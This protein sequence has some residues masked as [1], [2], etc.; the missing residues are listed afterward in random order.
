M[1]LIIIVMLMVLILIALY[2]V[3]KKGNENAKVLDLVV[4]N[5]LEGFRREIEGSI[6][7]SKNEMT[8]ARVDLNRQAT[9]TLKFLVEMQSTIEKVISQQEEANKLGQSLKDVLA[10]PK[11]RGNYGEIILEDLLEK[12]LPCGMWERQYKISDGCVVDV[13]VKYKDLLVPIDA[14]FP[15]DNY[16]KYLECD[17]KQDKDQYWKLF[18]R[19]LLNQI[20]ETAKYVQ[21][22]HGT[23]DFALMFIPSEA[24]YYETIADKNFYGQTSRIA[25]AL[26]KQKVIAVS[27]KNFYA[28]LQIVL[29]SMRNLEVLNHARE[30]QKKL[31][32]LQKKYGHFYSNYEKIGLEL[33]KA[34]EAY[35]IGDRHIGLYKKELD[36]ILEIEEVENEN[37]S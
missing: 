31:A 23:A 2:F 35:K 5:H 14:K 13:V 19:D 25:E 18:E 9:D 36:E 28:F 3:F 21:P 27:P 16:L 11:L 17:Q 30:V 29:T 1:E 12:I 10:M 7:A 22:E 4:K 15:R 6:Q 33:S 37:V 26:E 24:V 32:K 34:F 20:K 8:D